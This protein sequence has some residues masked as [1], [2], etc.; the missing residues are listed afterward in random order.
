[1]LLNPRVIIEVL[2]ASTERYDRGKTFTHYQS[3]PTLKEYIL[4]SPWEP[5]VD[6][7]H[8]QKDGT[9]ALTTF[10]GLKTTLAFH[11]VAA[12]IPLKAIYAKVKLNSA[13][14]GL[15]HGPDE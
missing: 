6:R 4:V 8:L 13:S 7:F 14:L 3:I 9:W 12:K 2:S 11:S 5:Q 1:M 15:L 10:R